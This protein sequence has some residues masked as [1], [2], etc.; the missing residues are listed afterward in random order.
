MLSFLSKIFGKK[1]NSSYSSKGVYQSPTM[2]TDSTNDD[3]I[4]TSCDG[5]GGTSYPGSQGPDYCTDCMGTGKR[6]WERSALGTTCL[7]HISGSSA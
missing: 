3:D 4:C 6:T 7:T 5:R 1:R 2:K